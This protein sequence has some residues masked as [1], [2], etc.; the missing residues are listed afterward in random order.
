MAMKRKVRK[1]DTI[2]GG[3]MVGKT[4]YLTL[5]DGS[6]LIARKALFGEKPNHWVVYGKIINK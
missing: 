5:D 4:L 1:W 2:G 6:K 3:S